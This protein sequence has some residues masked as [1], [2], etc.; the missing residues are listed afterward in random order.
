M[1]LSKNELIGCLQ[2]EVHILTHLCGKVE[3]GMLGYRPTEKQ[4]STLELLQYLAMMGPEILKAIRS[5]EFSMESWGAAEAGVKAMDFAGVK[6]ALAAQSEFYAAFLRGMTEEELAG[7]VTLFESRLS[8][9][10]HIID[11]VVCGHAAYRTQLFCYLK[12]CGREEL[13]TMNLWGGVDG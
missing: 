3:E 9:A 1:I 13:G 7:E 8:R 4:R 11:W 6:V 10:R 12:A 2:K 5:G